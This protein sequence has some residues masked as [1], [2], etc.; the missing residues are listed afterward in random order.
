MGSI[1]DL[2]YDKRVKEIEA[3]KDKAIIEIKCEDPTYRALRTAKKALAGDA[4]ATVSLRGY[5]FPK[6]VNDR[7]E[8]VRANM[9]KELAELDDFCQ[10]VSAMVSPADTTEKKN[11]LL[12]A[13]G[14][15]NDEDRIA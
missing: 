2:Y 6:E 12:R 15:L 14:I 4:D 3:R 7:I 8:E 13:Y 11:A 9:N 5:T 1:I 10:E